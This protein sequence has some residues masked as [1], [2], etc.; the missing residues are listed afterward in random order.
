MLLLLPLLLL[1]GALGAST[2][3]PAIDTA[4]LTAVCGGVVFSRKQAIACLL[5]VVDTNRD[6]GLSPA[7]I[8]ALPGKYLHWWERAVIM[9]KIA[10]G[11]DDPLKSILKDCDI[12]KDGV[13]TYA[14]MVNGAERCIP[15]KNADG[16][17]ANGLCDLKSYIC[18][19]ASA[20]LGHA[21]YK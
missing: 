12:D 21:T 19:R 3:N 14:D 11:G 9:V 6:G 8:E 4:K 20:S 7:E 15:A 5:D 16:S 18:D 10:M 17:Q 2:P 13:I 1:G